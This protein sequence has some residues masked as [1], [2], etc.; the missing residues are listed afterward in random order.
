MK[1]RRLPYLIFFLLCYVYLWLVVKPQLI[2]HG[3][4]TVVRDVPRFSTGWQFLRDA[5]EV[6]GGVVVYAHGFLS[7]C[8]YYSGLGA[9]LIVL[10]ALCLAE[11][12]RWHYV[13]AGHSKSTVLPYFPVVMIL[14]IYTHYDHPLAACLTSCAGLL[15]SYVLERLP[16]HRRPTRLGV[17][18]LVAG[19]SYWLAGS[20]GIFLFS[21]MTTV[22]LFFLRR[23]WLSAAFI[24]P[25]TVAIIWALADYV[26]HISPKQAF[27]ILTPFSRDLS[28]D[29]KPLSQVWIVML[30]AFVPMT[31]LLIG[32]WRT[33]FNRNR[34][35]GAVRPP[36]KKKTKKDAVN[37]FRGAFLESF[38]NVAMPVVPLVVLAVSLLLSY[39]KI[40]GHIVLI[41]YLARQKQWSDVLDVAKRLPK[42]IHSIYCNHDINRALYHTGRL[43]YDLLRFPQDPY[44]LLLTHAAEES[45]MIQLKLC[46]TFVEIGNVDFAEKLASEFLVDKGACGIVLEKLAWINVIKQQELT[47]Q[48]YLNALKKDLVYRHRADALL[49]GLKHGFE[50]EEAVAIRQVRSYRRSNTDGRLYTESIE[51][52]LTGLL[53][54]NPRNRMAFEYLMTCYLL[55]GQLENIVANIEHLADLGYQEVPPL[56]EEAM[57]LYHAARS[58][59]LNLTKLNLKRETFDRY[60]RFV[61]LCNSMQGHNRKGALQQ[62][63]REFGTGYFFYYTFTVSRLAGTH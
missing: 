23:D 62:L 52:M 4:G 42:H 46:D 59:R 41:N 40:H 30:Y 24:L 31:V 12:S 13:H 38:L 14:L 37:W 26:F 51:G 57:L 39:D 54:H 20:G 17:F 16:L 29:M 33:V 48:V 11:L 32:V 28:V 5:L 49:S 36:K 1:Y 56:Y 2:Y 34:G 10:V 35:I 50:P 55:A 44:A 8:Y 58:Q 21:L 27:L 63:T 15:F 43:G 18:C 22:Y 53:A 7:Q 3:F 60:T 25:A 61:K 6:P 47:A 19:L 45:S 9:L